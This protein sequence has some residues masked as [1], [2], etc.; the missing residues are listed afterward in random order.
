VP[1]TFVFLREN[2][3]TKLGYYFSRPVNGSLRAFVAKAVKAKNGRYLDADGNGIG[4]EPW[5][6][7]WWP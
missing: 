3:D 7:Y 4:N 2:G 5:D 1:G 6:D